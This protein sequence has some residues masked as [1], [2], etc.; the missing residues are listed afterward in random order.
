MGINIEIGVIIAYAL[1]LILLYIIGYLLLFPFKW[2]LRLMINA[3][4]GGV[5]LVVINLLGA[6]IGFMIPLNIITAFIVGTLGVP[7][8][9]MLTIL[10]YIL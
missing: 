3:V 4:I 7:G 9:I 1:G 2:V 10:K 5:V 6:S 8:V